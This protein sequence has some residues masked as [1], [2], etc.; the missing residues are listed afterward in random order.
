MISGIDRERPKAGR[1]V[2]YPRVLFVNCDDERL[3]GRYTETRRPHPLAGDHPVMD[4]IR[5]ERERSLHCATAL[6]S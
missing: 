4:G 3:E 6:I 1:R 2:A 5:V